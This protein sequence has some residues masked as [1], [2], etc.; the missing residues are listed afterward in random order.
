MKIQSTTKNFIYSLMH[1][2]IHNETGINA[3]TTIRVARSLMMGNNRYVWIA[4]RAEQP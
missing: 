1:R 3:T 4:T 2:A